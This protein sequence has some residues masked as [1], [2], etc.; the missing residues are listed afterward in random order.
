M[1][2]DGTKIESNDAYKGLTA[3]ADHGMMIGSKH[4][5]GT[6]VRSARDII[7]EAVETVRIEAESIVMSPA[8]NQPIE[9]EL[10]GGSMEVDALTLE[11]ACF[12]Y[13]CQLLT[14]CVLCREH[15]RFCRPIATAAT[16]VGG[17]AAVQKPS[18]LH[19]RS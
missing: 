6:A 18:D 8:L 2:F 16:E 13:W 7:L 15:P 1:L 9:M 17:R 12:S 14:D 10:R 11:G 4:S 19:A 5:Q 3:R